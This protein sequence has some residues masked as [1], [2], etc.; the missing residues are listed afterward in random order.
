M[1]WQKINNLELFTSTRNNILR[2]VIPPASSEKLMKYLKNKYKFYI[3]WSGSLFWIEVE[4]KEETKRSGE[5]E[6]PP[7]PEY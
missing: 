4:D 3:D 1:F 2:V 6:L 5:Y 7:P